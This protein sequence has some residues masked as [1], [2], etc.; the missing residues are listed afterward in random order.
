MYCVKLFDQYKQTRIKPFFLG[1]SM[2]INM[3]ALI[4]WYGIADVY[5]ENKGKKSSKISWV[6]YL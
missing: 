4:H 5:T 6:L 3:K 2:K 1:V